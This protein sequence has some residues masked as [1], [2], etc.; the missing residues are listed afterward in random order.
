MFQW[1]TMWAKKKL[2]VEG[3]EFCCNKKI[4]YNEDKII[5]AKQLWKHKNK[6]SQREWGLHIINCN[7]MKTMHKNMKH[8]HISV[9]TNV[10]NDNNTKIKTKKE[11]WKLQT[12]SQKKITM[13]I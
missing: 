7:H 9:K 6:K 11:S 1:T 10:V 13:M 12:M 5:V 8:Q 4:E 3:Y 2:K